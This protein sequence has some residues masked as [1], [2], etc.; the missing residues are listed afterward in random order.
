M[1]PD[2]RKSLL[3]QEDVPSSI[4]VGRPRRGIDATA[5]ALPFALVLAA[6]FIGATVR[7]GLFRTALLFGLVAVIGQFLVNRTSTDLNDPRL[8][9][10][11]ALFLLKLL[12]ALALLYLGW[13]K[14]LDPASA[15]FGY[16]PQRYYYQ[17][18]DL[19]DAGWNAEGIYLNYIG[20]LYY[21]AAI[22]VTSG[23]N[24]VTPALVN[25]LL[26]LIAGLLLIRLA[27][28]IVPERRPQDWMLGLV[29]IFP[30]IL[31]FDSLTARETLVM[32]TFVIAI[33]V[34]GYVVAAPGK[35][36]FDFKS[37][38]LTLTAAFAISLARTSML[39]PL[40]A[41]LAGVFLA[42]RSKAGGRT[43]G[44]AILGLL[45][46]LVFL[47]P[48][49]SSNLGSTTSSYE[50]QLTNV[51]AP[52]ESVSTATGWSDR[53]V[54]RLLLPGSPLEAGLFVWPRLLLYLI[55][56]LP[57]L[58]FS[59]AG[60]GARAWTDWQGLMMTLSSLAYVI[61]FPLVIASLVRTIQEP[62]S[63][64]GLALQIPCWVLLI[65]IAGGNQIIHNRYRVMASLLVL[66]CAW[67]GVRAPR[68]LLWHVYVGWGAVLLISA[69]VYTFIKVT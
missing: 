41:A 3:Q 69:A 12:L 35:K 50:E 13:M 45:L 34:V 42:L 58:E 4:A 56:P 62:K 16:D 33:A 1:S 7:D 5:A 59:F 68:R 24:V 55:A 46:V 11:G 40:I 36:Q 28:A 18:K 23:W 37:I 26:T 52:S 65:S 54:G 27:Y 39:I 48:E 51:F 29:L 49:I 64:A 17:A 6:V 20:V 38:A 66:A 14:D 2:S 47:A 8:R 57:N 9:R 44:L 67:L 21:F 32:S 31:W 19:I 10:L 53:S 25:S 63:R 15:T 61:L 60:L 22:F 30:E 43:V